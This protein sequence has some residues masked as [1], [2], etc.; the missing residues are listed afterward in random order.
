[1]GPPGK[2]KVPDAPTSRG[3]PNGIY[4]I[5]DNDNTVFLVAIAII[6]KSNNLCHNNNET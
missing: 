2:K 5:P 1:M 6:N 4:T 3:S